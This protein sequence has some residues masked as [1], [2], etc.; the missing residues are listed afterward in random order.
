MS[1]IRFLLPGSPS[2]EDGVRCGRENASPGG[3]SEVS[4]R[5]LPWKVLAF[6]G[7]SGTCSGIA[8]VPLIAA[9]PAGGAPASTSRAGRSVK[10]VETRRWGGKQGYEWIR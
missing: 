9:S 2:G 7:K 1:A 8:A 5:Y 3:S 6:P 10:D 4:C